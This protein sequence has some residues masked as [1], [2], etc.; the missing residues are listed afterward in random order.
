MTSF[1]GFFVT[2]T[3]PS[4]LSHMCTL[5]LAPFLRLLRARIFLISSF[6]DTMAYRS[7]RDDSAEGVSHLTIFNFVAD[8]ITPKVV[9]ASYEL[10]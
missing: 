4:L 9:S 6:K 2:S 10:F 1:V 8:P 5:A 3:H 7:R